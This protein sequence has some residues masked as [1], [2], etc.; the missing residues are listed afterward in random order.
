MAAYRENFD[1]SGDIGKQPAVIQNDGR[2]GTEP[3]CRRCN[4]KSIQTF[5]PPLLPM[6]IEIRRNPTRTVRIGS[7]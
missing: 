6:S 7:V 2:R 4:H 5:T 3:R 1:A